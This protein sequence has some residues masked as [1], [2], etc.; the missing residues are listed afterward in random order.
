MNRRIVIAG[1]IG[2]AIC[3]LLIG[4]V[5]RSR[6][7]RGLKL[8]K[9]DAN[10][11]YQ[12]AVSLQAKGE[13][14]KAARAYQ[15]LIKQ[16]PN[17]KQISDVEKRLWD[18]NIEVL[19]SPVIT[20]KDIVYKVEPGDT[21]SKIAARHN[22]TVDLIMRS[23]NL[24][25]HLI[26]PRKRLKVSGAKYS[27]IIDK[28]QNLLTLKADDAIFKVYSVATGEYN[29]TPTG[30]FKI[31]EKLENPPWYK[32]GEGAIPAGSPENILGTRWLGLSE[33]EYGIHGGATTKD[34]GKQIT[35]GCIRMTN[36]EVEELF[37]ILPRGAEVI[38]VE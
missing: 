13:L 38:I 30:A 16:F 26:R 34:L 31:M 25:N 6:K 7:N 35:N 18:L 23:N 17:F 21:L 28:S 19:F 15:E 12:N 9:S 3:L 5:G 37:T 11:L 2:L 32:K 24:K 10:S 4:L 1:L 27:L 20:E 36:S 22:T 33:P 14:D 8:V 29:S